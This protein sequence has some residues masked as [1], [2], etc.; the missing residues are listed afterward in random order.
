M[1]KNVGGAR[2]SNEA[3]QKEL[4]V[5]AELQEDLATKLAKRY[6][7]VN[8]LIKEQGTLEA[9]NNGLLKEKDLIAGQLK[10]KEEGTRDLSLD[11]LSSNKEQV[12][13]QKK[14]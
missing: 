1:A 13:Q 5:Q 3:Y 11:V 14:L 12:N 8:D 10:D 6:K 4:E 7:Q 2:V 9:F